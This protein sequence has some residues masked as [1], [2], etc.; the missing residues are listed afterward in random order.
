MAEQQT[1][2]TLLL[3]GFDAFG[4][5]TRNPSQVI[6]EQIA[7]HPALF[8]P[9]HWRLHPAILPT[10]FAAAGQ[11]IQHL[12]LAHRP[13]VV[14]CLG[15][16]VGRA[17]IS[18]ECTARNQHTAALPDNAGQ[19]AAGGPIVA[20]GPPVYS[21]TL[22]LHALSAALE[23]HSIP[24]EYSTDAGGY[25]CNHVFYLACHT[26]AQQQQETEGGAVCG[27]L[28]VPLA[29]D[30]LPTTPHRTHAAANE[31]FPLA[32]LVEAIGC[33]LAVLTREEANHVAT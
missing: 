31:G 6:V 24:V 23:Q 1:T 32:L 19:V 27:F 15:V 21:A 25:V 29:A 14:V 13:A 30:L 16:A 9:Q 5:L 33:C 8:L 26:L 4:G 10:V 18:L 11:Q 22:P 7:A 12:I 3:T 20:D 17:A 28:H 2:R